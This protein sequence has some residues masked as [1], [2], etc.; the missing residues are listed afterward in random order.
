MG[1]TFSSSSDTGGERTDV[2]PAL[3]TR[4]RE[5]PGT[6]SDAEWKKV[7]T[8]AQYEVTRGQGTEPAFTGHL[9]DNKKNGMYHCV[10]CHSPLFSS[11]TKFESGSGWPSFTSA[12]DSRTVTE[13]SDFTLGMARTEANCSKCRAHLGHVF[14]DGPQ[15]TGRRF[16][17]NSASLR[18]KE[19]EGKKK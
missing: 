11:S 12:S 10:C 6:M 17:I 4:A 19:K 15:P 1:S 5:D 9:W 8:N 3:A 2:D 18:F 14:D 16:C 13:R 7:L